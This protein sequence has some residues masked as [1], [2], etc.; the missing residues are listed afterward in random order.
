M[1][2]L[3]IVL[4]ILVVSCFFIGRRTVKSPNSYLRKHPAFTKVIF[5]AYIVLAGCF[6]F[7]ISSEPFPFDFMK[8]HLIVTSYG[9]IGLGFAGLYG[10]AKEKLVYPITLSLTILGMLFRYISEYGEVSNTYNFT[11]LNVVSYV[12]IMPIF[13]VVIYHYI[14]KYLLKKK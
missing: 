8:V 14:L 12:A 1:I 9:M 5:L 11:M 10:V 2:I 13:T 6:V 7:P 3:V 4:L